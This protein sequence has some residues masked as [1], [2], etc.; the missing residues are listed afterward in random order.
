MKKRVLPETP[1]DNLEPNPEFICSPSHSV[2]GSLGGGAGT[3]SPSSF[4][5]ASGSDGKILRAGSIGSRSVP[6]WQKVRANLI[7][8]ACLSVHFHVEQRGRGILRTCG[9]IARRYNGRV[10]EG[11]HK[12]AL[13]RG[14]LIRL[15]RLWRSGGQIPAVFFLNFT[16]GRRYIDA[17]LLVR[18][19]NFAADAKW[20]SFKAAWLAFCK[21]GG[22]YGPGRLNGKKLALGYDALRWNLPRGSFGQIQRQWKAIDL[23]QREA[24]RLRARFIAEITAR[25]PAKLPRR[26]NQRDFQI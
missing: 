8:R 3:S 4:Q 10:I 23:A 1:L 20:T 2:H 24:N 6:K 13:S 12:L 7:H 25:V 9:R 16:S 17:R 5:S 15:Y 18:F 14:T 22:S 19:I 26:T 11:S 21:R